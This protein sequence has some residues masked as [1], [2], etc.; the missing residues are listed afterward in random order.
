MSK[1]SLNMQSGVADLDAETQ[2]VRTVAV[3]L[4]PAAGARR[5]RVAH[6]VSVKP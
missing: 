5:L 4:D 1:R 6:A 2:I 3:D